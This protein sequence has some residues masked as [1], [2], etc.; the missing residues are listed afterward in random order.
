[1]LSPAG[2]VSDTLPSCFS[3]TMSAAGVGNRA[4]L[5][6]DGDAEESLSI[7]FTVVS[8]LGSTACQAPKTLSPPVPPAM[9]CRNETLLSK[10]TASAWHARA[11]P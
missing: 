2:V 10:W 11:S 5:V 6:T 1:M 3:L 4:I 8:A 9:V 7:S